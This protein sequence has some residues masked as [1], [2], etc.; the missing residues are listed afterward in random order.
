MSKKPVIFLAFANDRVD[1]AAYL[2]NLPKELHGIREA[3]EQVVK[4]G[5]CEVVERANATIDTILDVFQ[6]SRYRDRIAIMHYGGH[7]NGYQLLLEKLDGTHSSAHSEGLVSFLAKQIGLQLVFLNGCSSQQQALD[8]VQAGI[9]AVIG[10]SQSINDDVATMLSLRFYQALGNGSNLERAWVEAVDQAKIQKGTANMRDLFW[11]GDEMETAP[12]RFPWEI[13]YRAGAELVKHWN[14]PE[15]ADNPLF[16]LPDPSVQFDLPN[17]PYRFLQRYTREHAPIFFGRSYYIR[18]LYNSAIDPVAAP[19]ILFYGQS[20]VGKSSML[21][22]GV[23]PRLER[24]RQ[25][26]YSRR[27][28]SKGLLGTLKKALGFED[29][30]STIRQ[31]QLQKEE[32]NFRQQLQQLQWIEGQATPDMKPSVQLLIEQLQEKIE[33]QSEED[34]SV[35]ITEE[36]ETLKEMWLLLE[37]QYEQ[38]LVV[39]LD[40]VEEVFTRP[41]TRMR[42]ELEI[43]MDEVKAI[44]SN[45]STRPQGK[46]ILSYRKEYHPE[47]KEACTVRGLPKEEVFLKALAR[48]DIVE[49]VKGL[50]LTERLQRTYQLQVEEDLPVIIADDLLEDKESPIAPVL[51]ILLTKM[52]RMTENEEYQL[53]SVDRYQ[54]LRKQGIL[55]DD[56]FHEQMEHLKKAFPEE[57]ESGLALGLLQL[58]ITKMGTAGARSVDELRELYA[59]RQEVI[60]KLITKLKDL[61]LLASAGTDDT[62]L[63]HDTLA[64]LVQQEFR[65]SNKPAQRGAIIVDSKLLAFEEDKDNVIDPEDLRIVEDGAYGMPLFTSKE[66]SL[67][68]E[69]RS[70]RDRAIANKKRIRRL[71]IIAVV[72]IFFTAVFAFF[73]MFEA[74]KSADKANYSLELA[75]A[76]KSEA[77]SAA[78]AA[79]HSDSLAQIDKGNAINARA[80]AES[81][82]LAAMRSDSLAQIDKANAIN[83]QKEADSTALVALRSDS[84][85]QID[86]TNAIAAQDSAANASKR[87]DTER[88]RAEYQLIMATARET[89]VQ[90][91]LIKNN[92]R[93]KARLAMAAYDLE[94]EADKHRID[95]TEKPNTAKILEAL[96]DAFTSYHKDSLYAGEAWTFEVASEQILLSSKRGTLHIGKVI[97]DSIG[98]LPSFKSERVPVKGIEQVKVKQI[99]KGQP[100]QFLL[101]LSDGRLMSLEGGGLKEYYKLKSG[102]LKSMVY[103]PVQDWICWST[104]D[105]RVVIWSVK[106]QKIQEEFKVASTV[107]AL[108]VDTKRLWLFGADES[109][110]MTYWNLKI[111]MPSQNIFEGA[112]GEA[113][114]SLAYSPAFGFLI[115]GSVKGHLLGVELTGDRLVHTF[116][117]KHS[118]LVKDL[119][120]ND[121][122]GLFASASFDGQILS[123]NINR[124]KGIAGFASQ[125]PATLSN[126][127][128]ILSI[129]YSEDNKYLIFSDLEGLKARVVDSALLY[130]KLGQNTKN[131]KLSEEEWKVYIGTS[132]EPISSKE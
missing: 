105:N 130:K 109:G 121:Q 89:A 53:F 31:Q 1:D 127:H 84:L 7:A 83:A 75:E 65:T 34:N 18:D 92:N 78:K 10:T 11:E 91:I 15:S 128:K 19:I 60:D 54:M 50:T 6:D 123:W 100:Q 29:G 110:Q 119:A 3:L 4:E 46:L 68:E 73:Q 85:A 95:G 113:L 87:A 118:G 77:D 58:H 125:I 96:S 55:M 102:R 47:I 57:V 103:F 41:N 16:G 25:V 48:K 114:S 12:D 20:G 36:A 71:G 35:P 30:G 28:Q 72:V 94:K 21:D 90:S 132:I 56:F 45:P 38:P 88:K 120:F 26:V 107:T 22:A 37:K 40:Q 64:P 61:Y 52:W 106:N 43:F 8:L 42:D 112:G 59:D 63:A 111:P 126:D 81:A 51:Q 17:Q 32:S 44:F 108:A 2:R 129:A 115:A 97:P 76:A 124:N 70:R 13:Y 98:G 82:T 122:E 74:K 9:P 116:T 69:S 131:E 101:A 62:G 27:E 5:L 66:Q 117:G 33:H 99:I 67:I 93:L 39:L 24:T 86:K 79:H 80:V 49:V 23:F 104:D 14:L